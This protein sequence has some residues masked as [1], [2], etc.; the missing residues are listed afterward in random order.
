MEALDILFIISIF[1]GLAYFIKHEID[2]SRLLNT[3]TNRSRGTKSEQ[4]LVI[5]LL[6]H[7]FE[8]KNLFHDLYLDKKS[9]NYCQ[10]DLVLLTSVGIIVLEVKDCSGWIFGSGNSKNWT[11]VLSYGRSKY[12]LY[13]PIEQNATHITNL[14][15]S[16]LHFNNIPFFSI[17]VFFGSC[18]LKSI[19]MIPKNTFVVKQYDVV[20]TINN[21][22]LRKKQAE[23]QNMEEIIDLLRTASLNGENEGIRLAH[24]N[25]VKNVVE[26]KNRISI[27]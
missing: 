4:Q 22:I 20:K 24:K 19:D 1:I 15:K 5:K 13:N 11:Q 6:R 23:Y 2:N 12:K 25:Y 26:Y 27:K 21:L 16:L 10:I 14:K 7:K 8:A 18:E 17:I 9:G 3:V